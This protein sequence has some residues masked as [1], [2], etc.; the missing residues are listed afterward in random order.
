MHRAIFLIFNHEITGRQAEDARESLGVERIVE[1][2]A[3]LKGLW[4]SVPPDIPEI[5][6]Y[7]EPVKKW[8]EDNAAPSDYVLV[9]GDFGATYLMVN[10]ALERGLVPVYSTTDRE[11]L[12]KHDDDGSVSLVHRFKHRIFRRYGV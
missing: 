4:K 1:P 9:Q 2:P 7:L 5:S 11:A 12:E 10:F 8:L 3:D 6:S